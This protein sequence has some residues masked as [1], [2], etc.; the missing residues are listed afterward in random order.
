[1]EEMK[2]KWSE[3]FRVYLDS[4]ELLGSKQKLR[5]LQPQQFITLTSEKC[6]YEKERT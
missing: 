4:L 5:C 6:E 3:F 2:R 1:M